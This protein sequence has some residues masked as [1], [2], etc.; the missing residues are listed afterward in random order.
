MS[1]EH[2]RRRSLLAN[3]ALD[4]DELERIR[5]VA[6]PAALRHTRLTRP[7]YS[8]YEDFRTIGWSRHT[9]WR[10]NLSAGWRKKN[11]C[12]TH[13]Q[14]GYR[15]GYWSGTAGYGTRGGSTRRTGG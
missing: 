11:Q 9:N 8:R 7:S 3:D 12:E 5:F 15:T 4:D 6:L 2:R 1:H 13:M 14:I 10:N